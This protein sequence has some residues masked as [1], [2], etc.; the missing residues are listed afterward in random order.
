MGMRAWS[1]GEYRELSQ[2]SRISKDSKRE[3]RNSNGIQNI[4]KTAVTRDASK[5][6]ENR[7]LGRRTKKARLQDQVGQS[8]I[9]PPANCNERIFEGV[10]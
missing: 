1:C 9:I 6:S 4:D 8:E 7:V 10:D 5:N 3:D 2:Q